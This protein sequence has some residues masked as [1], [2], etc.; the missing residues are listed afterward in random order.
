MKLSFTR[1]ITAFAAVMILGFQ[2]S[3]QTVVWSED[4]GAGVIPATWT[5]VDATS[6]VT[7]LWE[8]ST[9]GP[10]FGA[11][12]AFASPTAANGFAIFNSDAAGP[13]NPSHDLQL[14]TD[15]I[16]CSTLTTTVVAKF[17]NQYAYYSAGGVSIVELGVS[18]DGTTFTYFPILVGI[19]QNDLTIAETTE[20]VDISTVAAGQSTVYLQFRWRG[21]YEYAWRIDD[22]KV[23]DG[24]TPLPADDV[25]LASNFYAIASSYQMPIN[26]VDSVRF[27]ADV[28]NIGSN[29][30]DNVTL[31]VTVIKDSDNS[32]VH[33]QS[34]NYGTLQPADTVE[35]YLFPQT[36]LAP[37]VAETYTATYSLS[38]DAATDSDPN[39]NTATFNFEVTDG[40]FSKVSGTNENIA[41]GADNSWTAGTHYYAYKGT[42]IT[43]LDTTARYATAITFGIANATGAQ[44]IAGNSV[45]VFL[46]KGYDVDGSGLIETT[47]RTVVAFGSYTFTANDDDIIL[48]VP[49]DNFSGTTL[50]YELEDN[51]HYLVTVRYSATGTEDMFLLMSGA[52]NY[53]GA[54]FAAGLSNAPRYGGFLDIG[55]SGDYNYITN[56][57]GNPTPAVGLLTSTVFTT[58]TADRQLDANSLIV[59][60]NPA[61]EFVTATL[62]LK[63][64]AENARITI[65]NVHGQVIE[66]RNLSN[67]RNEQVQFNLD[68]YTSGTYLMSIDT[69][70]GHTIKRFIV[71][72]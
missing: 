71:K 44:G 60:P 39:N 6:Q 17:S 69:D 1:L 4:F 7:T 19:A 55:N 49:I 68:N 16:D 20:E 3:A 48:A 8:F 40:V 63:E 26:Q 36:F 21:N 54:D 9:A 29:V 15:V 58:S 67:V 25:A 43:G 38:S 37:N 65:Y 42:E 62:D 30:Q 13:V 46:E 52:E 14:T 47:E 66:T 18:T 56:F 23:Q 70:F 50:L 10:L 11:Q 2:V 51:S 31:T 28:A 61:T 34:Y 33:T 72:K 12:P 35:N 22:I 53:S 45:D 59:F 32:T 64:T 41:P 57:N 5:N 27:L 24:V